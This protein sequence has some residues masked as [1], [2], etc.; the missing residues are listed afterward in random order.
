MISDGGSAMTRSITPSSAVTRLP[1]IVQVSI[2]Y[3]AR[4]LTII[5]RWALVEHLLDGVPTYSLVIIPTKTGQT[6]TR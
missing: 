4:S 2:A 1:R 3:E 6:L 5:S